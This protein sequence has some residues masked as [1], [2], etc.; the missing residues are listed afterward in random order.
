MTSTA[1][2]RAGAHL[3]AP[4]EKIVVV[5]RGTSLEELTAKFNTEGQAR[6]YLEH[7]GQDFA[8]IRTRHQRYH[9]V[10]DEVSKLAPP[11]IKLQVIDR[12]FLP[13]RAE[14][15]SRISIGRSPDGVYP[16]MRERPRT[17]EAFPLCSVTVEPLFRLGASRSRVLG[18]AIHVV[19]GARP[20]DGVERRHVA[21]AGLDDPLGCGSGCAAG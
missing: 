18:R 7:A 5:T 6:F 15:P 16:R 9:S 3:Q 4:R 8:P 21:N 20:T 13:P 19:L 2:Q 1:V 12:S 14:R 17:R 10:L 11:G